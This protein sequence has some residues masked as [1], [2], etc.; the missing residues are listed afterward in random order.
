MRVGAS[1]IEVPEELSLW[2]AICA[3][4]HTLRLLAGAEFDEFCS[5][6]IKAFEAANAHYGALVTLRLS[7]QDWAEEL[8]V[9]TAKK[10][11]AFL[12]EVRAL[13]QN[14]DTTPEGVEIWQK[15][16]PSRQVP[17]FASARDL[18]SSALGYTLRNSGVLS[19]PE[20]PD[21]DEEDENEKEVNMDLATVPDTLQQ[22]VR[23]GVLDSYDAW[24]VR[25]LSN[26]KTLAQLAKAPRT[27][28]RFGRPQIPAS[29]IEQL[30]DRIRRHRFG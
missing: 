25:Q 26:R 13:A 4:P 18:W 19:K 15:A 20:S 6:M 7:P 23:H 14:F 12:S 29:Y 28:L 3:A 24:L 16:W 5:L 21:K 27:L 1:A 30:F 2:E 8:T 22:Y 17:G 9:N 11:S 10:I